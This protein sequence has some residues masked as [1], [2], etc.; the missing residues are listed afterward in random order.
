M[1][2]EIDHI[3]TDEI[4]CPRCGIEWTD[5][6]EALDESIEGEPEECEECHC[7]F[8]YRRDIHVTYTTGIS[9]EVIE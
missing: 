1:S 3:Y 6:W 4:V 9:C 5:S 7:K 8:W 2:K